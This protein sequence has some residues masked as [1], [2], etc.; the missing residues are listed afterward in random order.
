VDDA[1]SRENT[2]LTADE[3]E[4]L[5]EDVDGKLRR[6][7]RM[8]NPNNLDYSIS[9]SSL[10]PLPTVGYPETDS[11]ALAEA[12]VMNGQNMP[13]LDDTLW[14]VPPRRWVVFSDLHVSKATLETCLDVLD[15]VHAEAKARE[16]GVIFLG[17]FWHERGLLRVEPLNAVLKAVSKWNVPFIALPGNHDQTSLDGVMHSL[18]PLA[19]ACPSTRVITHPAVFLGALWFPYRRQY[20]A[21][22]IRM[23]QMLNATGEE[24]V[25]AIF[26]HVDV[27]GAD[28]G[29]GVLAMRGLTADDFPPHLPVY[30]GHYHKPHTVPGKIPRV[31][32]VQY[33]GSPYQT[34]M[35]EAGEEKQLL[36]LDTDT[37]LVSEKI[38][39]ADRSLGKRHFRV[40]SFD[41]MMEKMKE[42]NL[43]AGD[44]VQLCVADAQIAKKALANIH[45]PGVS[46]EIREEASQAV[47]ARIPRYPSHILF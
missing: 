17:D 27:I 29:G 25:R 36:V 34:S 30:T 18:T 32:P 5:T 38:S 43:R 8:Y 22:K 21:L 9:R 20:N 37:W 6:E 47:Q 24:P 41:V 3:S 11:A 28:M 35:A 16:A 26:C 15:I 33:V 40:T 19:F 4:E 31:H 23:N 39:L 46:F 42:W 10:P 1:Y 14:K 2:L 44:R 12:M 13:S 45:V 7:T